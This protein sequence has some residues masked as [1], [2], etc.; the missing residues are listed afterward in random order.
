VEF[1]A[2]ITKFARALAKILA[3]AAPTPLE[4]PVTITVLS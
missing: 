3:V 1:L 2:T 4:A